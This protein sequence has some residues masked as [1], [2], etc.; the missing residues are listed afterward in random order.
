MERRHHNQPQQCLACTTTTVRVVV[1]CGARGHHA[2]GAEIAVGGGH[3]FDRSNMPLCAGSTPGTHAVG[4]HM[5]AFGL[6]HKHTHAFG[7]LHEYPKTHVWMHIDAHTGWKHRRAAAA[8][9]LPTTRAP[10]FCILP[11]HPALHGP[12]PTDH[13]WY[14]CAYYIYWYHNHHEYRH[15]HRR[16]RYHH[17][18][19]ACITLCSGYAATSAHVVP[20]RLQFGAHSA[21]PHSP[22]TCCCAT[23][24]TGVCACKCTGSCCST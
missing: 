22:N 19:R 15:H 1:D 17:H 13:N 7:W 12:L 14:F 9:H 11:C 10:Q 6:L 18:K 3:L 2:Q 16:H 8:D 23:H 5:H 20:Y 24:A 4:L 21:D